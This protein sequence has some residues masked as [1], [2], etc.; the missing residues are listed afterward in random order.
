MSEKNYTIRDIHEGLKLKKFSCLE[1]TKQYL[2]NAKKNKFNTY[3]TVDE[4]GALAKAK[5]VDNKLAAKKEI[6]ILEGVPMAVKDTIMTKGLK[7]TAASKILGNYTAVY[8]ATVI[9]KLKKAGVIIIGK[10][11]CDEFA[12]GASN[13]NSAYGPV[14]NPLDITRVPGGSSGGS[15]AAVSSPA[16]E[17]VFALGS[18]TGG[19]IRQ[20]AAFCGVVGLKPTYGRVSRYGLISLAS[21]FDQIGPI[22]KNV[23]DA[24]MVM[25]VLAG[26]DP[27]DLTTQDKKVPE[28][29][30]EIKKPT[31]KITVGIIKEAFEKGLD[32]EIEQGINNIIKKIKLARPTAIASESLRA[33]NASHSEAGGDKRI[34]IK[35]I[36]LPSL[37]YSLACY[38]IIQPAEASANLARY[39]GLRFGR[40]LNKG[41]NLGEIY[42]KNRGS[43]F[44]PEVRRRII[45]GTF[46]LSAGYI[47]SY[48]KKAVAVRKLI[49]NDFQKALKGVDLLLMPTTPTL[50]F[51]IGE[52]VN[53]PLAMYLSDIFTVSV[54][55]AGLPA[56]SLPIGLSKQKLPM[57]VQIVGNYFAEAQIL[58][59]S[60]Y[61]ENLLS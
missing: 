42:Q 38:Y 18:D 34:R 41:I 12:M 24:A 25:E 4:N 14:K 5:E 9:E 21:S 35:E 27:N 50:P 57:A 44:G 59:F 7:T 36:S 29:S 58:R 30:K 45:M 23:E 40:N 39:D 47:E 37:E 17:C 16:D 49:R 19:S 52:K 54:N 33:G 31:N 3:I 1:I 6:G 43:G 60:H 13:E 53:D 8:D 51:K 26:I 11:N 10:T 55:I 2:D 46:V 48:Y 15:A 56:L 22:T 28:Y 61:L 32:K 20:P